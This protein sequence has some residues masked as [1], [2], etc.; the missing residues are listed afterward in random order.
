MTTVQTFTLYV[1]RF[2]L[3]NPECYETVGSGTFN[4][5]AVR[6]QSEDGDLLVY[7]VNR[8]EFSADG[9]V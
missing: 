6:V 4:D 8:D 5:K 3:P 1:Y 9:Y 2:V 7:A